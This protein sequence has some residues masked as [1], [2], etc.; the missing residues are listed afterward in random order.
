M[1]VFCLLV[2]LRCV[3]LFVGVCLCLF[4]FDSCCFVY[5]ACGCLC[6]LAVVSA[7]CVFVRLLRVL[8]LFCCVYLFRLK[9]LLSLPI[10]MCLVGTSL[11]SMV[12]R[13]FLNVDFVR[14][15]LFLLVWCVAVVSFLF[16]R[17][18]FVCLRL[19]SFVFV[20]L[21]LCLAHVCYVCLFVCACV[22]LFV[23]LCV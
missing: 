10:C 9:G 7:F 11:V 5:D 20:C 3:L 2:L 21:R 19:S 23:C 12:N 13:L 16:L 18:V 15:C 6:L 17:F 1:S 22:R 14:A 8:A 4:V